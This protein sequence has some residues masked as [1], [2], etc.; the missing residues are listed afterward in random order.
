M[1]A[2]LAQTWRARSPRERLTLGGG[3]AL[4]VL[5]LGYA[6]AWLPM[7]RDLEQLRPALPQLR[8]QAEQVR[9]DAAEVVRLRARPAAPADAASLT[10]LIE[11]RAAASGLRDRI[12][13][14]IPQDAGRIRIR[15]AQVGFDAWLGWIGELQAAH[16]VRVESVA[17]EATDEAGMVRVEAVM[18]GA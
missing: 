5:A 8:A 13:T 15:L 6:Y 9:R 3:A 11:R 17:I 10:A 12:E 18:A 1:K 7:Q 4:L 16:G 14:I 2:L